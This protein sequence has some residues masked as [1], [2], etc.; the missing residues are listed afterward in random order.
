MRRLLAGW[1]ILFCCV[2]AHATPEDEVRASIVK[3][4][5]TAWDQSDYDALEKMAE[6]YSQS[7]STTL[8]GKWRLELYDNELSRKLKIQWP[9][10]YNI[11]NPE[12]ACRCSSPAPRFYE[13]ADE[14][15]SVVKGKI[16]SWRTAYPG[17][18]H[19]IVAEAQYLINRGWFYRGSAYARY[20]P[21]EAWRMLS[22]YE[23]QA[24]TLLES[25]RSLSSKNPIWFQ[26]MFTL[27]SDQDW[28]NES[29]DAL[30]ADFKEHGHFYPGALNLIFYRLFPKW[31]G[32]LD[33]MEQFARNVTDLTRADD[34]NGQY[35]RLY[36]N[37]ATE[38][39]RELFTAT[40]A[41]WATMRSGLKDII[42]KYP[43]PR[44]INAIGYFACLA[45]DYETMNKALKRLGS[46]VNPEVWNY[47]VAFDRCILHGDM[48]SPP[49]E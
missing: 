48:T 37:I 30:V 31:G 39:N 29:Y 4:V 40:K 15:W 46:D 10:T 21:P 49:L 41:D 43:D 25:T 16:R 33:A 13:A 18:P 42:K 20:V 12:V 38:F 9:S 28:S 1:A 44:N 6:S 47:Y 34:G 2:T 8:S 22:Q 23:N 17:S 14:R 19:A 24:R 3:A 26:E 32:S 35:A 45:E 36:W 11:E 5:D 7:R 27:A